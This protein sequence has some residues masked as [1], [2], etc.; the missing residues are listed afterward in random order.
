MV[1]MINKL[2]LLVSI[3][4]GIVVAGGCSVVQKGTDATAYEQLAKWKALADNAQASPDYKTAHDD[5]N[6][7]ITAKQT[8]LTIT[9]SQLFG[10]IKLDD[11]PDKLAQDVAKLNKTPTP[12]SWETDI[13]DWLLK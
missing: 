13:L 1:A 4:L 3:M 10:Q 7:W 5:I 2:C 12:M 6:A 8:Q 9:G 11:F